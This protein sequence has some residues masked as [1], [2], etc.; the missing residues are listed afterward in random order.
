VRLA[1]CRISRKVDMLAKNNTTQLKKLKTCLKHQVALFSPTAEHPPHEWMKHYVMTMTTVQMFNI[2]NHSLL[3]HF[4][5]I[6]CA[7]AST[8]GSV[9]V[10]D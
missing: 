1:Q 6:I 2:T 4:G 5:L 8:A 3:S 10:A 7:R 9:A